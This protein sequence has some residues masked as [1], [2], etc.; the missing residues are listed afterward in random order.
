[1]FG[2]D[3]GG[4]D[5]SAG[6]LEEKGWLVEDESGSA[7]P[8]FG[9][10]GIFSQ[11]RVKASFFEASD[12]LGTVDGVRIKNVVVADPQFEGKAGPNRDCAVESSVVSHGPREAAEHNE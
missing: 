12:A 5:F 4:D 6:Q 9:E 7:S 1:M 2:A 10:G 11:L 3:P 8:F